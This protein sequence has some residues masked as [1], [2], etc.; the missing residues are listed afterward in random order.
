ML[1]AVQSMAMQSILGQDALQ[2]QL[3]DVRSFRT[4]PSHAQFML[5]E[6]IID[7]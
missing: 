3:S 1:A 7:C 2:C 6:G 5:I 4:I